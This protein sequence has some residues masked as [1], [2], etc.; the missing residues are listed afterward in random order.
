MRREIV[1]RNRCKAWRGRIQEPFT[2]DDIRNVMKELNLDF[3]QE[4][5]EK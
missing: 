3:E 1:G 5:K 4:F 2:W